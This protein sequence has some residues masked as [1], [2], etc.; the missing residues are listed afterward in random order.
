MNFSSISDRSL[1]GK[2]LRAPLKF[3]PTELVVP[4]LQGRLKGKKWVNGS[5]NHGC[6]LGS[7]ELGKQLIFSATI[8]E[9]SVVFDL[10]ANVGF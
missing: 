2:A 8:K 9:G 3:I 10:G 5:S 4:I 7:Y 1:L 6:W